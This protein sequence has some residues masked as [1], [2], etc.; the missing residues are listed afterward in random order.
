M[1]QTRRVSGFRFRIDATGPSMDG[2]EGTVIGG[3]RVAGDDVAVGDRLRIT[4]SSGDV[5][6]VVSGFP[7]IRWDDASLR[8]IAVTGLAPDEAMIGSVA[9]QIDD[10]A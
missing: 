7:L 4:L 9:V 10:E 1:M 5:D 3:V 6:V 8:S 2:I